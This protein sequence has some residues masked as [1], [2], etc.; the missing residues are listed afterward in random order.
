MPNLALHH[1]ALISTDIDRSAAFYENVLGFKRIARPPFT[2]I[3]IWYGLGALQVH[4]VVH[5]PGNFRQRGVDNDD[6]HFALRTDDFDATVAELEAKG[7]SA[8]L[9]PD[10]PQKLIVKKTGMA[11]FPQVFLCDPDRNIIEIN[12]AP[13]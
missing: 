13:L 1:V 3:G 2:I 8:D 9:P 4:L 11:G 6:V 10:H 5:P 7:Y 12:Q